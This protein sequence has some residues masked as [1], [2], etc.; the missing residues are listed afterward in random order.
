MQTFVAAIRFP[1]GSQ[2]EIGRLA[3]CYYDAKEQFQRDVVVH[4][5]E[6]LQQPKLASWVR[7][8]MKVQEPVMNGQIGRAHV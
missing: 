4:G 2:R 1:D 8:M 7:R 5:A 3:R 6:K